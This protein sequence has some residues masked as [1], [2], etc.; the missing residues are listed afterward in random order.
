M[1][2][3]VKTVDDYDATGKSPSLKLAISPNMFSQVFFSLK[4]FF[5]HLEK[6]A[7]PLKPIEGIIVL[8][9]EPDVADFDIDFM[10]MEQKCSPFA[11]IEGTFQNLPTAHAIADHREHANKFKEK[12]PEAEGNASVRT[13]C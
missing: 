11:N 10:T 4:K 12:D 3:G 5:S 7:R 6:H 9:N 13:G 2:T 1:L 8:Y